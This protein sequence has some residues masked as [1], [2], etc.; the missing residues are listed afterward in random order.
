MQKTFNYLQ[1]NAA[2]FLAEEIIKL[3]SKDCILLF[4][5]T[6]KCIGDAF[7]PIVGS[8]LESYNFLNNPIFGTIKHPV[9]ALNINNTLSYI[10][11]VYPSKE[12]FVID[13]MISQKGNVGDIIL[14]NEGIYP[15]KAIGNTL[16]KTGDYSLTLVV[17]NNEKDA[18]NSLTTLRLNNIYEMAKVVSDALT[19]AF[20]D[21]VYSVTSDVL[22]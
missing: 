2:K 6:D 3:I 8:L 4:I 9:H 16:P 11:T 12:I 7:A 15:G 17:S 13:S 10:K 21:S 1:K 5:G 18:I 19:Y 20:S 22:Q 14:F